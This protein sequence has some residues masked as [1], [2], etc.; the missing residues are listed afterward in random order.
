MD[1]KLKFLHGLKENLKNAP[2]VNGQILICTNSKEM[3]IDVNDTRIEIADTDALAGSLANLIAFIGTLPEGVTATTI[4]DYINEKTAGIA[5]DAALQELTGRVDTAEG[6]IDTLEGKVEALEADAELHADITYVDEE[7]AKKAD[8]T[9]LEAT[10]E[11]LAALKKVID[12]FF[13][14]DAAVN[15]VIDTLKEITAYIANDKEGAADLTARLGTLE[16][17]VDVEKVSTAIATAKQEAAE[18]ATTK[19]ADAQAAAEAKAAELDAALKTELQGEIDTDIEAAIAAEVER[20]DEAYDTKGAASTAK[21]EA[22]SAAEARAAEL[23]AVVLKEAQ[24][25][26][27]AQDEDLYATI[28][29]EIAAD[30]KALADGQVAANTS[31]IAEHEDALT[32]GTF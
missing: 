26:V 14:E 5:T 11:T 12:D 20:A 23:D 4:I 27:K 25:Y 7:L 21:E 19:A 29:A 22:I 3:F 24:D 16:T 2:V 28:S 31:A 30:V 9:A 1:V 18:D 8:N 10:N 32:W 15:D 17:K 13:A 6:D